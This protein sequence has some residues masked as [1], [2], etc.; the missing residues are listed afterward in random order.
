MIILSANKVL[1][2][3]RESSLHLNLSLCLA[4]TAV[5]QA[6]LSGTPSVTAMH[7]EC[8]FISDQSIFQPMA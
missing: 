6:F 3:M 1:V 4:I 7:S 5:I 8:F 2:N